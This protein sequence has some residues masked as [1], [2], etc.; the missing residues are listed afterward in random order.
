M[1]NPESG[2]GDQAATKEQRE[3]YLAKQDLDR[4]I[5]KSLRKD[6][7]NA[8]ENTEVHVLNFSGTVENDDGTES[9][10]P[11]DSKTYKGKEELLS[12][13]KKLEQERYEELQASG[14][15]TDPE[16]HSTKS[17]EDIALEAGIKNGHV[18]ESRLTKE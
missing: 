12:G 7:D 1:V 17:S 14:A 9:L 18:G 5:A 15:V 8:D 6:A 13:A 10:I 16:I 3:K 2:Y 11:S 4:E